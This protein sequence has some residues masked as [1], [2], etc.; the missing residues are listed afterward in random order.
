MRYM[1]IG[2]FFQA[3]PLAIASILRGAGKSRPPMVYN[4]VANVV[5][6]MIGYLLINGIWVFPK[7][8]LEGAAIGATIAKAVAC[9]M[10][11]VILFMSKPPVEISIKDQI[12]VDF[13]MLK[14]IMDI[15]ISAAGEQFIMRMGFLIYTKTIAELGTV[16]LASHQVISNI[17]GL[18]SNV[19]GGFAIAASSYTGRCLGAKDAT[20]ARVYVDEIKKIG[21]IFSLSV[22]ILF[23]V[24]GYQL[25][26]IFTP[27]EEVLILV[28]Q[29]LIIGGLITFPQNTQQILSGSLRGA[30]DTKWPLV[31]ALVT[32]TVCRVGL[33]IVFVKVFHLGLMGAWMAALFDQSLRA[34]FTS[35]RYKSGKWALREV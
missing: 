9:M 34:I 2:A 13:K 16:S 18:V 14:R 21:F 1:S 23:V 11:I 24:F 27:D 10:S 26:K 25:G 5:N 30:G 3:I 8:G 6:V 28:Q 22:G 32:V 4:T 20:L 35:I 31:T 29:V 19:V 33:A 15:S 12:K 17:T 7:L